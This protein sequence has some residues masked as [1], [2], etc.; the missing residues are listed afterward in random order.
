MLIFLGTGP[1]SAEDPPP[2]N[3]R[4]TPF[5]E[6]STASEQGVPLREIKT[7]TVCAVSCE[8]TSEELK[9]RGSELAGFKVQIPSAP[10]SAIVY[11]RRLDQP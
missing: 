1:S 8:D 11:Y 10:G 7:G 9:L 2:P 6:R 4:V 3:V 5:R